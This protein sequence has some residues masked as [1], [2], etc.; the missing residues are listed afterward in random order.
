MDDWVNIKFFIDDE[1]DSMTSV[2]S[3]S[4]TRLPAFP[5]SFSINWFSYSQSSLVYVESGK[6]G[7]K[8]NLTVN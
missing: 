8:V 5:F 2:T 6:S 4:Y 3:Y 7:D 1:E